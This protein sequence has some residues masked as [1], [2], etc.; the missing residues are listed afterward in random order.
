MKNFIYILAL[1]SVAVP[2]VAQRSVKP[3]NNGLDRKGSHTEQMMRSL[4]LTR[5]HEKFSRSNQNL[6]FPKVKE[7]DTHE[8]PMVMDRVNGIN[9]AWVNYGRD[10]GVD[11]TGGP[12]F[13]AD[14]QSF[15]EIMDFVAFNGGNVLRWW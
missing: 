1:L 3:W 13:R 7:T 12:D 5:I 2:S 4:N 10:T 8:A 6:I 11:P 15:E 9:V 14:L